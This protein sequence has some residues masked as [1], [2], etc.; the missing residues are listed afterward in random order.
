MTVR[1][2][3]RCATCDRKTIIKVQ[4]GY[5]D[6]S[7]VAISCPH[8][9]SNIRG[10]IVQN[11]PN[12]SLILNNCEILDSDHAMGSGIPIIQLSPEFPIPKESYQSTGNF[13]LTLNPYMA[14]STIFEIDTISRYISNYK[15]FLDSFEDRLDDLENIIRLFS[16]E[17]HDLLNNLFLKNFPDI[18]TYLK[19]E[20]SP[21]YKTSVYIISNII[22]FLSN[23]ILPKGYVDNLRINVLFKETISSIKKK[24]NSYQKAL[25]QISNNLD[26]KRDYLFSCNS[27]LKFYKDIR[28]FAPVILL[29]NKSLISE[30]KND[31]KITTFSFTEQSRYYQDNFELIVRFFPLTIALNNLKYR[32]DINHFLDPRRDK[33]FHSF[34]QKRDIEK[35]HTMCNYSVLNNYFTAQLN[36]EIRNSIA[37]HKII[38]DGVNQEIKYYPSTKS[39]NVKNISLIDFAHNLLITYFTIIDLNIMLGKLKTINY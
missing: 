37:H 18:A 20:L 8:C 1:F 9:N 14:I 33:D 31:Y 26:I 6:K 10:E 21:S 23:F 25:E 28:E 38:Y 15:T 2:N 27:I 34:S 22:Q 13:Y 29:S 3:T 24:P 36:N 32:N 4:A 12:L 30:F 16:H 17:K 19:K 5:I 35:F 11:P 39:N 7:P